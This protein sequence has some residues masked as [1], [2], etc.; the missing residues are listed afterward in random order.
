MIKPNERAPKQELT[1]D[2]VRFHAFG[3]VLARLGL[4]MTDFNMAEEKT[5]KGK[6]IF[7]PKQPITITHTDEVGV[8]V[9]FVIQ[10][11]SEGSV[12][13]GLTRAKRGWTTGQDKVYAKTLISTKSNYWKLSSENWK[14]ERPKPAKAA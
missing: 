1:K 4:S 3:T 2:F 6:D 14:I 11:I 9:I 8:K 5:K 7:V 12:I 10:S 13:C